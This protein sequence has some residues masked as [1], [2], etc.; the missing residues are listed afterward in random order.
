MIV[1]YLVLGIAAGAIA[2]G[3]ALATGSGLVV[4][5]IAYVLAGTVGVA[6]TTL[7]LVVKSYGRLLKTSPT[8]EST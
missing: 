7:W 1:F 5:S 2:A 3:T 6:T 8:C 4:A